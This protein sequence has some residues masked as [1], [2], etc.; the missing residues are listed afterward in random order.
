MDRVV[1][2]DLLGQRRRTSARLLV[3][4]EVTLER[5][6]LLG[7]DPARPL[8]GEDER[9]EDRGGPQ[10]DGPVTVRTVGRG[11]VVEDLVGHREGGGLDVGHPAL[12]RDRAEVVGQGLQVGH[13]V[14]DHHQPLGQRTRTP[15]VRAEHVDARLLQVVDVHHV[16]DVPQLVEVGPAH[17]ALVAMAHAP[18]L[19]ESG[20]CVGRGSARG[21]EAAVVGRDA[22][23]AGHAG[24][25]VADRRLREDGDRGDAADEGE[26]GDDHDE[27]DELRRGRT[28]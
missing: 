21:D 1:A 27:R 25:V 18:T 4:L 8:L 26:Q 15:A 22:L 12:D 3:G 6:P 19:P 9:R 14:A 11:R 28:T 16:V 20:A 13:L 10:V 17:R 7:R 5:L 23:V 2:G 24:A